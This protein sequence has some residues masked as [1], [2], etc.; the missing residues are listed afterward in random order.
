[1]IERLTPPAVLAQTGSN[2][3]RGRVLVAAN[4]VACLHAFGWLP[5]LVS[6]H[7]VRSI[8]AALFVLLYFTGVIAYFRVRQLIEPV[9]TLFTLGLALS[10]IIGILSG[11]RVELV[12][13]WLA[14]V[15]LTGLVLERALIPVALTLGAVALMIAY[16]P[17]ARSAPVGLEPLQVM[18]L[19][20]TMG[21]CT[22]VLLSVRDATEERQRAAIDELQ[23]A[24]QALQEAVERASAKARARETFLAS[25]NHELRTPLNGV[26]GLSQLLE[27]EEIDDD[28]QGAL[29][30][31]RV[32]GEALRLAIESLIEIVRAE[33][34]G[35]R[36]AFP[37]DLYE[38]LQRV[39]AEAHRSL[40]ASTSD[41][42]LALEIAPTVPRVVLG[43]AARVRALLHHLFVIVARQQGQL[44]TWRVERT[45]RGVQ[46]R[47]TS[48]ANTPAAAGAPQSAGLALV[49]HL[50]GL[51]GGNI[52]EDAQQGILH[53]ELPLLPAPA[54]VS[55]GKPAEP[56]AR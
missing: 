16:L 29:G 30:N 13:A 47:A 39:M 43:D 19:V 6:G 52:H 2:A 42:R 28:V 1:M 40:G 9:A 33:A 48:E 36:S 56:P 35:L 10:P 22:L 26:L 15:P 11:A 5:A 8:I 25:V 32:E 3:M 18:P 41:N 17:D 4:G 24:N 44:I 12:V 49:V 51:L 50:L 46:L 34:S 54:E 53:I 20:V 7:D 31:V 23:S 21:L 37:F 55:S 45:P 38:L 27:S 14:L